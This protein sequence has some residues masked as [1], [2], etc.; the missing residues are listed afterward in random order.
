MCFCCF[1]ACNCVQKLYKV[2][3]FQKIVFKTKKFSFVFNC[4]IYLPKNIYIYGRKC[5]F[6]I[7]QDKSNAINEFSLDNELGKSSFLNSC[8]NHL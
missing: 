8:K 6:R 1:L 4:Y 3:S 7:M 5:I 2:K